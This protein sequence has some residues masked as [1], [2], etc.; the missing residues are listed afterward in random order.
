MDCIDLALARCPPWCKDEFVSE[1][2][3]KLCEVAEKYSGAK[4]NFR[5]YAIES[6]KNMMIDGIRQ[7]KP[8]FPLIDDDVGISGMDAVIS[9]HNFSEYLSGLKPA[10]SYILMQKYAGYSLEEIAT[11]MSVHHWIVKYMYEKLKKRF[12][13]EFT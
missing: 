8:T 10:E 5:R 7:Q 13:E 11:E 4:E 2:Y 6:I 12:L 9:N 1:A 3:V